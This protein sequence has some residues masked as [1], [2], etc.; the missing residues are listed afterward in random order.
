[1]SNPTSTFVRKLASNDK[2]TRESAFEALKNFLKSKSSS[3]LPLLE[4]EKLWKGLY[5]AMWFCDKPKPQENL[6]E[7][8]GKLYSEVIPRGSWAKF[9]EAFWSIITKEWPSIDQW[10]IDKYY[11][12]VRRVL[13]HNF[14]R[15]RAE[16][17]NDK[18]LQS[19]L[20]VLEKYPLSGEKHIPVA[21]PYHLCDIYVEELE[22]VIFEELQEDDEEGKDIENYK[23]VFAKKLEIVGETPVVQVI[24][25]FEKL[26]KN[27]LLK[28]LREKSKEDVLDHQLLKDWGVFGDDSDSEE[29]EEEEEWKGF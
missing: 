12:L 20:G 27:A 29:E 28:T 24:S 15:L 17:W 18:D 5:F 19:F 1:M 21:M 10:R 9:H 3:N 11:L 13:R 2:N 14:K 16:K 7:N 6:A 23:E 25:P 8:L 22:T 4:M 26:S